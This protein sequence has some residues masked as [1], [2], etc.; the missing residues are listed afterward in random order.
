[1]ENTYM[2]MGHCIQYIM[3]SYY[4]HILGLIPVAFTAVAATLYFTGIQSA[5][6]IPAAG[7]VA[8]ALVGHALFVNG[9]VDDAPDATAVTQHQHAA[10]VG[11]V[12]DGSPAPA[13]D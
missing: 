1:M 7:G 6:A 12:E 10:P 13:A 2:T 5:L 9:P 4:D 3:T 11:P 8:V